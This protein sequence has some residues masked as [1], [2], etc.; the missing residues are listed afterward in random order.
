MLKGINH[1][2]EILGWIRIALSPIVIALII[3][4]FILINNESSISYLLSIII[5]LIGVII[6]CLWASKIIKTKR[7]TMQ[8]L[9]QTNSSPRT[10]D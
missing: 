3:S 7:G 9:S 2:F 1:F 8:Y 4:F 10:L 5:V 6:G